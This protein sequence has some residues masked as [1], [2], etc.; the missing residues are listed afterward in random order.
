M[1]QVLLRRGHAVVEDVP[2]PAVERGAVL[3]RVERSCISTGTELS[4]L[5]ATGTPLWQRA[6]RQ[7]EQVRRVVGVAAT[8]GI[9]SARNLITSKLDASTPTGYSAAGTVLQVGADVS[10]LVPGDRVACAGSQ[11]AHHAEIIRVPR[12][13]VVRIPDGLGFDEASTVTLGAIALQGVRRAMP[14]LGETFVVVGL[15]ILGQLTAQLLRANGCR[16]I[17]ADPDARRVAL[18]VDLGMDA[19]VDG[20][21]EGPT[22]IL[23]LTDGVG[24][25]GVIVTASTTSSAVISSAFQMCRRKGRVVLVGDVGLD[26]DRSDIYEKELD[27]L[28][29]TSYGPGRYDAKYEDLGLDYPIGYVRW[30][31][32]RNMAEYLRLVAQRRVRVETFVGGTFPIERAAEAYAALEAPSERPLI[33]L[34]E[35]PGADYV[36]E[37]QTVANPMAK[38]RRSGA[39]RVALV[40]AGEFATG[41]HLPNLAGLDGALHL[42]AVVSRSPDK[43]AAVARQYGAA[44]ATTDFDRVLEDPDVDACLIATR[45]D[46]HASMALDALRH[47]KHVLVEKP[48]AMSATELHAVEGFFATRDGAKP[49][50]MTGF[51]RRFSPYAERIASW[52]PAAPALWWRTIASTPAICPPITGCRGRKVVVATLVRHATCMTC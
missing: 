39:V 25:D 35:Y 49:I 21:A 28:V 33:V 2:A 14:T 27:F 24:A 15:G 5:H 34:L 50:L 43:A 16:V 10:D 30:T 22:D 11:S 45:H 32:N 29:S 46:L 20:N 38:P 41:V 51:N 8:Q 13:L 12:N 19:S 44:Y 47:G 7:P 17:G 1:K 9:R 36:R 3:V 37:S 40:G 26:L 4:S 6:A 52:S 23:R 18:A 31:E 42:Q 48:L